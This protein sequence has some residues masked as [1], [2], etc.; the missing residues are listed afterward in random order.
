MYHFTLSYSKDLRD[1]HN[2][3]SIYKSLGKLHSHQESEERLTGETLEGSLA[4]YKISKMYLPFHLAI[5]FLDFSLK[6]TAQVQTGA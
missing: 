2:Q 3:P 6:M 5:P 1:W 4:L